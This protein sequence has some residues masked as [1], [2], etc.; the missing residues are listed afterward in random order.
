[1]AK[2][3]QKDVPDAFRH[4][5]IAWVYRQEPPIQ[6]KKVCGEIGVSRVALWHWD[7]GRTRPSGDAMTRI[8]EYTGGA[9]TP[10]ACHA[11]WLSKQ[12]RAA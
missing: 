10:D 8:I 12:E 2:T 11:Y 5:L 9:V 4:P 3:S 6:L 1:M 7:H